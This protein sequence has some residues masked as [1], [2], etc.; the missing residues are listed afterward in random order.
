MH[1][2]V[3]IVFSQLVDSCLF[4]F[5]FSLVENLLRFPLLCL[6]CMCGTPSPLNSN[7][8]LPHSASSLTVLS[9][10]GADELQ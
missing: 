8:V 10:R 7:N 9:S 6:L 1:L 4:F 5:F 2:T 3:L